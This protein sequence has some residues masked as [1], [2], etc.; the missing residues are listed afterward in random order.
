MNVGMPPRS[1]N[2]RLPAAADAP[3]ASA[4]SSLLKPLTI[5][6]QNSRSTSR[7]SD[8]FPGDFIGALPVSSRIHPAGLPIDT[9]TIKVLR[10]P[11]ESAYDFIGRYLDADLQ[12]LAYELKKKLEFDLRGELGEEPLVLHL[13]GFSGSDIDLFFPYDDADETTRRPWT[14]FVRLAASLIE[15]TANMGFPP[16]SG[17]GKY[18]EVQYVRRMEEVLGSPRDDCL[19]RCARARS[20]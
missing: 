11:V 1:L 19:G 10:R 17:D 18:L 12:E 13:G 3:T 4:A 15:K 16:F 2:Q 7:R 6:R 9:S 14:V 8:G 5:S 20:L